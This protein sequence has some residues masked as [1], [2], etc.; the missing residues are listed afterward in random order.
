MLVG[1]EMGEKF[2]AAQLLLLVHRLSGG[3]GK[4]AQAALDWANEHRDHLW[5]PRTV[6]RKRK[7]KKRKRKKD[8]IGRSDKI[9]WKEICAL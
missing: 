4:A 9:G 6:A 3:S 8:A 1:M 5:S 2:I 7:C